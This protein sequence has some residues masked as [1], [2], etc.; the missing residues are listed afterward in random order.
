M[1]RAARDHSDEVAKRVPSSRIGT[2]EDMAGVAIYLASRAGDY[3][4]GDTIA[5]DGGMVYANAGR[6]TRGR[7][8]ARSSPSCAESGLAAPPKMI[9]D[10]LS[11][12]PGS[13]E[14]STSPRNAGR[15]KKDHVSIFTYS[16]SPGLLSMPT[17]GGEIQ[18]A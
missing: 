3:V 11:S 4:V 8:A 16:K 9:A 15:G 7:G 5:V 18:G 13:Q 6:E 14:R 10:H 12:S 1:N 2:D 17:L